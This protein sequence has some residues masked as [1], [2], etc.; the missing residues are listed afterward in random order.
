MNKPIIR[1]LVIIV[2]TS[3]TLASTVLPMQ[4]GSSFAEPREVIASGQIELFDVESYDFVSGEKGYQVGGDLS[5]RTTSSECFGAEIW[6]NFPPQQGGLY[7]FSGYYDDLGLLNPVE[8]GFSPDEYSPF[9]VELMLDGVYA[10]KRHAAP[11]D[12]VIFRV[13]NLTADSVSLTYVVVDTGQEVVPA[14]GE[15]FT[16]QDGQVINAY[17]QPGGEPSGTFQVE[18][19]FT[20]LD[21]QDGFLLV[22]YQAPNGDS[23][24]S[25]VNKAEVEQLT[26]GSTAGGTQGTEQTT[27]NETMQNVRLVS[28]PHPSTDP[29]AERP[30]CR[31]AACLETPLDFLIVTRPFFEAALQPFIDWKSDNGYRIGLVSVEWLDQTFAG[32]HMAERMK[33]GMHTLRRGSS[34]AEALYVLLVGDTEIEMENFHITAVQASFDLSHPWN[35]PTGFYRRISNDPADEVLPSDAYFVEDRDWDPD[36]TGLNPVPDQEWGQGTFD[37]TLYLGRWS[38]RDPVQVANII[39]KTMAHAPAQKVL[40]AESAEFDDE[41]SKTI[42]TWPPDSYWG[43]R[44]YASCYNN[45]YEMRTRLFE[46]NS[47]WLKTE[48]LYVEIANPSEVAA[49]Y[50]KLLNYDGVVYTL[51]HG[52]YYCLAMEANLCVG[53]ETLKFNTLLPF[54]EPAGCYVSAVYSGREDTLTESLHNAATGPAIVSTAGHNEYGYYE[55]LRLGQPVGQA[56]WRAGA[57][58]TYWLNPIL[59]QGDPSLQVFVGP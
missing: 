59:L 22:T 6:A 57:V 36:N 58:Y 29:I 8:M 41:L 17:D 52:Y 55:N 9:C 32:R 56:F 43:E 51:F 24:Q 47:P 37:A 30:V 12:Y 4:A 10:Y 46:G 2:F 1:I 40:F 45:S 42:C 14:G 48:S 21:E 31:D 15:T 34:S 5:V 19:T 25:W 23:Y 35:V 20:I 28:A 11:G 3:I 16:L 18:L 49:F 53:I 54:Y 7:I 33:T 44:A 38:V 50:D 26:A 27:S 13:N 39:A